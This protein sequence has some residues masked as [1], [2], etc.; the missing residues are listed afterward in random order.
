MTLSLHHANPIASPCPPTPGS[1]SPSTIS[2][3]ISTA[4][5][6]PEPEGS[7]TAGAW[8]RSQQLPLFTGGVF[9]MLPDL[10]RQCLSCTEQPCQHPFSNLKNIKMQNSEKAVSV[11]FAV[12][13]LWCIS[14]GKRDIGNQPLPIHNYN[15][16]K[17]Q[18][19]PDERLYVS[20]HR[21]KWE[22]ANPLPAEAV[23][24]W[25]WGLL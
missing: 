11:L 16:R 13:T 10:A 14:Y 19:S 23:E 12:R 17:I 24:V 25:C 21:W 9:G 20:L 22:V 1:S 4:T 3:G 18:L 2:A 8:A 15:G 5:A 6:A 7:I